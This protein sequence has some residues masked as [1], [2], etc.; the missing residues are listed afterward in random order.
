MMNNNKASI[1]ANIQNIFFECAMMWNETE[2]G[3]QGM[4]FSLP[5][6]P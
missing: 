2:M 5:T 4:A 3:N 6:P 1:G